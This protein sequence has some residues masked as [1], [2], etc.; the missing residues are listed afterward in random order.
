[1]LGFFV[2][3]GLIITVDLYQVGIFCHLIIEI[4]YAHPDSNNESLKVLIEKKI[5]V[6]D[7]SLCFILDPWDR[8]KQEGQ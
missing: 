2:N 1:M 4:R 8:L 6:Q 3:S 7:Y 5:S